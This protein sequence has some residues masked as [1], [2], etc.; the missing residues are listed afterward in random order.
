M[1]KPL[2]KKKSEKNKKTTHFLSNNC[3]TNK[4]N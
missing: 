1:I 3:L 4:Q 2:L